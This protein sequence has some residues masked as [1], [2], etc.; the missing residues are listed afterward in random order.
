MAL[1]GSDAVLVL[2]TVPGAA[3]LKNADPETFKLY[4]ERALH[5]LC[6]AGLAGFPQITL[7]IGVIDGAPFGLSLIGPPNSDV[8][9]IRLG[10]RILANAGK[11]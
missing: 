9:L 6:I 4:R 8:A 2:P 7:P 3:P 1:L 5:L 11:G 10:R